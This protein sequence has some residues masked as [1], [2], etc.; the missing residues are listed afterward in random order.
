M[1]TL[2]KAGVVRILR[3]RNDTAVIGPTSM[4]TF[5]MPAIVC[6]HDTTKFVGSGKQIWI[7][8]RASSVL[9]G[10]DDIMAK[11]SQV[12]GRGK[13]KILVGI[14]KHPF[15]LHESFIAF[16]IFANRV[17]DFLGMFGRVIPGRFQIN[18]R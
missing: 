12:F 16:L 13:R 8:S 2:G 1:H 3:G 11:A 18:A 15:S 5:I 10:R 7:G 9:L 6:Q 14:K 17:I 4:Q